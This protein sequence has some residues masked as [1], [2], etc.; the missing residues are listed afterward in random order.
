MLGERRRRGITLHQRIEV[1]ARD[2]F[3]TL[4]S[5]MLARMG[6]PLSLEAAADQPAWLSTAMSSHPTIF[7]PSFNFTAC[8]DR[9]MLE[10]VRGVVI[11]S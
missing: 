5:T 9:P 2:A 4:T 1:L 10:V 11:I 7:T 6:R 8:S 3:E